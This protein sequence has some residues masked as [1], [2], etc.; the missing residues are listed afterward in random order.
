[1]IPSSNSGK[2]CKPIIC[3]IPYF[4]NSPASIK[5]WAPPGPSSAGWKTK[6]MVP[7][8]SCGCVARYCA[9]PSMVAICPS[10]PQAC[11]L[12]GWVLWKAKSVFSVI[13][14]ASISVRKPNVLPSLVPLKI[15][16][17]PVSNISWIS[18]LG[19]CCK[20]LYK[21]SFVLY[22][23]KP[24][25]GIWWSARRCFVTR[26]LSCATSWEISIFMQTSLGIFLVIYSLAY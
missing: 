21:Y 26:S 10:W 1:M 16:T 23:D 19:K 18:I 2:T 7:I 15:A 25:S 20:K 14:K 13:G 5:S 12:P 3:S 4:S 11:I 6:T 22:S 24:N 9:K 17:N 8:I